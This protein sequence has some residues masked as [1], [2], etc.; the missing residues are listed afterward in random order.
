MSLLLQVA[1]PGVPIL[2]AQ[3]GHHRRWM[4]VVQRTFQFNMCSVR[5]L[6][7]FVTAAEPLL[8]VMA[9]W[10]PSP[11]LEVL[12]WQMPVGHALASG[13]GQ[14]S[15]RVCTASHSYLHPLGHF[16]V[17]LLHKL[18]PFVSPGHKALVYT[19]QYCMILFTVHLGLM[20]TISAPKQCIFV[21]MCHNEFPVHTLEDTR[22][23]NTALCL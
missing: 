20:L 22:D 10:T 9:C 11:R 5:Q 8:S 6:Y 16:P 4:M 2:H 3:V 17:A 19:Q 23:S 15:R 13:R 12:C 1:E 14:R 21:H 7:V 18:T